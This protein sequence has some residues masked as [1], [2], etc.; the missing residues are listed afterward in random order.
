MSSSRTPTS[1]W[2]TCASPSACAWARS[3]WP[4]TVSWMAMAS[5]ERYAQPLFAGTSRRSWRNPGTLQKA[6]WRL[7]SWKR[8]CRRSCCNSL[9]GCHFGRRARVPL[10]PASLQPASSSRTAVTA[11]ACART[12]ALHRTCPRTTTSRTRRQRSSGECWQQEVRSPQISGSQLPT[13]LGAWQPHVPSETIG[14]RH[15]PKGPV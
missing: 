14:Q 4:C 11:A 3:V 7:R 9:Q 6:A 8:S 1:S 15:R 12:R 10:R 13:R 2:R 5:A